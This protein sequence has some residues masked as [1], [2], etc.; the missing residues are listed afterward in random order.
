[1][2]S[3]GEDWYAR[4]IANTYAHPEVVG[5]I[6]RRHIYPAIGRLPV[7]EVRPSHIDRTLVRIVQAGAPTVAND[8]MRYLF[9]MF[10]YALKKQW[11][12]VNPA[13]GFELS[14]AGGTERS[15]ERWL[16]LHELVALAKA[17]RGNDSFGRQ[18]ELS[19]WLLLALC[20]RKMELLSA[21]WTEFDLDRGVWMLQGARTKT[22]EQIEIPLT[23]QVMVWLEEV[24]V[25]SC[26]S[27]YLFPA[28]RRMRKRLG[29]QRK[30]RFEHV[31][32]DTLNKAMKGLLL[33]DIE[34]F[35]VHDMRRTARTHMASMGVS[36]FVAERALNHKLGK[37]EGIYDR[38]DYF[39]ERDQA[40][41]RWSELLESI[42]V[43]RLDEKQLATTPMVRRSRAAAARSCPA[44]TSGEQRP[45]GRTVAQ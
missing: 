9:R 24:R 5:R 41:E 21:K 40:L 17:M 26:G 11:V 25:F 30:N 14:D 8:V 45:P 4:Y 42:Q 20:V 6:L 27:A 31:C 16:Q 13:A 37:V 29:T 28:R 35:T 36:R 2:K 19:V 18:N 10:H 39:E 3:L 44:G 23:A 38:H 32:P 1:M 43:G 34:H 7:R 22:S 33:D 12:E 15:R